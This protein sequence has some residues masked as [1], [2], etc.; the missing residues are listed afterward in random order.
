[1]KKAF[2]KMQGCGNDYIYFD[3]MDGNIPADMP[4]LSLRLSDRHFGIGGDGIILICPSETADARM[5]IFNADGSEGKMCGNGVRCVGKYLYERLGMHRDVLT[6][7]TLSGVKTLRPAATDGV[8]TAVSV[9]MGPADFSAATIPFFSSD[10]QTVGVPLTVAGTEYVV[11]CLSMGNP[12]CVVF[13]GDPL[14]MPLEEIGPA[15]ER[16][17][18]FPESVNTEFVRVLSPDALQMRVWERGS[19][20]TMA[21]GTGACAAAAA[22]VANGLCGRDRDIE[23]KL[24]GGSLIIRVAPDTVWMTG[25]A[26]TA[27]TGETEI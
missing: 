15:F 23:V 21:C 27:F 18:A 11:T 20:E 4:Q 2:V 10:G 22:A 24:P 1:M 16:H 14:S 19:G 12:H 7:E 3:C 6:V 26:V 13:C 9:D 8:V 17:P 25:P 5:R